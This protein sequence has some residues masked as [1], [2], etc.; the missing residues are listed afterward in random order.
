MVTVQTKTLMTAEQFMAFP[1]GEEG[2]G[3]RFELLEGAVVVDEPLPVHQM[4]VF[5]LGYE[6]ETWIRTGA[7][8]GQFMLNIDTR[9]DR[10]NLFGPDAQW[11]RAGREITDTF[12]RPQGP[13]DIAIEILSPTTRRRDQTTKRGVYA[14]N[15][16]AELWLVDPVDRTLLALRRSGLGGAYDIEDAL[17]GDTAL[18]S[19]LLPGFSVALRDLFA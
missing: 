11:Y 6:F 15:G 14:R 4:V 13:G 1:I 19:P 16:V 12:S 8:R 10:L 3:H 5:A 17:E 9:L 18:T 7:G 2:D